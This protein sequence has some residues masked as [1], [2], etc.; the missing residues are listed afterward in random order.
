MPP[1]TG[2]TYQ[3]FTIKGTWRNDTFEL[4]VSERTY[5]R[6]QRGAFSEAAYPPLF[7]YLPL[8]AG[9]QHLMDVD[10][11]P[12]VPSQTLTDGMAFANNEYYIGEALNES[13][14]AHVP[15]IAKLAFNPRPG[16]AIDQTSKVYSTISQAF[17]LNFHWKYKT[18]AHYDNWGAFPDVWRT[19]LR[20]YDS[21][22]S[23]NVP[24]RVYNYAFMRGVGL[25]DFWYGSFQAD[26]TVK[27]YEIYAI[28]Y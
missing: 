20:E 6:N 10:D 22:V 25:V 24:D 13:N 23:P 7:G 4:G 14:M 11:T 17:L 12:I 27:G 18:V 19:G 3:T 28:D 15:F 2:I 9:Y 1:G 21:E 16:Q 8:T 5:L 26:G